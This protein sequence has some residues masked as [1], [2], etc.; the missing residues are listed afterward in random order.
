[1]ENSFTLRN[2][3]TGQNLTHPIVGLWYT[4]DLQEAIDAL[5]DCHEYLKTTDL[6]HKKDNFVIFNL[7]TNEVFSQPS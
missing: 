3:E 6:S 4:P 7:S 2:T 5:K 1:M